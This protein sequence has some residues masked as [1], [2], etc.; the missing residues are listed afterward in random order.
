MP[1]AP[2]GVAGISIFG[3]A[4]CAASHRLGGLS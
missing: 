1:A 2:S 3:E 4:M